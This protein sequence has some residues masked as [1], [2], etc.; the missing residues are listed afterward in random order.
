MRW[1]NRCIQILARILLLVSGVLLITCVGCSRTVP[2]KV[3]PL[4]VL[5]SEDYRQLEVVANQSPASVGKSVGSVCEPTLVY[6][7]VDGYNFLKVRSVYIPDF[8]SRDSRADEKVTRNTVDDLRTL[9]LKSNLFERV[10][11]VDPTGAE[12]ELDGD[13]GK[14]QEVTGSQTAK[15]V[16]SGGIRCGLCEMELKILDSKTRKTIGAIKINYFSTRTGPFAGGILGWA[17]SSS[18]ATQLPGLIAIA[19][20]KI[21]AGVTGWS[22]G[23]WYTCVKD[24]GTSLIDKMCEK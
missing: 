22:N 4:G 13:I 9:L 12:I 11:R 20:E 17:G 16:F 14:Y 15:A 5:E 3:R 18:P 2:M 19:L 10:E 1:R 7:V 6:Y 24:D 21:K 8:K 23:V